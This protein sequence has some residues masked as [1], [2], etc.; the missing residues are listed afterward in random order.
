MQTKQT[1]S[2]NT[3]MTELI[4]MNV[5]SKFDINAYKETMDR[6]ISDIFLQPMSDVQAFDILD[7][8]KSKKNKLIALKVKQYRMKVDRIWQSA[9]GNYYSF[10][11]L[12]VA[13]KTGLDIVSRKRRIIV[14]V[15]N[16]TNTDSPSE[17]KINFDKLSNYKEAHP[18]Y[19]CIYGCIND[20]TEE[21][22]VKGYNQLFR[23]EDGIV[24]E[25][26]AGRSFID[27][28]L[29]SDADAII[30]FI[31]DTIDKYT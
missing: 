29:G 1:T 9:L 16:S 17:R 8:E 14:K 20:D 3:T 6:I 21:K 15:K 12:R 7:T 10:I 31:R 27:Y 5:M 22:T 2:I 24:I 19:T 25:F 13:D 28:I 26:R 11:D 30:D 4:T 18:E 23:R